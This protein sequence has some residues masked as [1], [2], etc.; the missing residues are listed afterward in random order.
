MGLAMIGSPQSGRG[1]RGEACGGVGAVAM[2]CG[3]WI[4]GCVFLSW[5][6]GDL[7][8]W[9]IYSMGIIVYHT[10]E[11]VDSSGLDIETKVYVDL[12]DGVL[13]Y[14][15]LYRGPVVISTSCVCLPFGQFARLLTNVGAYL[16]DM[17]GGSGVDPGGGSGAGGSGSKVSNILELLQLDVAPPVPPAGSPIDFG[18]GD[19][20]FDDDP[21]SD[22]LDGGSDGD[23]GDV[24]DADFDFGPDGSDDD[25]FDPDVSDSDD[26]PLDDDSD[27][28]DDDE[29]DPDSDSDDPDSDDPDSND[30]WGEDWGW[31]AFFNWDDKRC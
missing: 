12:D 17:T 1:G 19:F 27:G 21:I 28:L 6:V 29:F 23:H 11:R 4:V 2:G 26:E 20:V 5:C 9:E 31:G 30:G 3:V 16:R 8:L 13:L 10:I 15:Y 25:E 7:V 18:P 22:D 24:F 14:Q